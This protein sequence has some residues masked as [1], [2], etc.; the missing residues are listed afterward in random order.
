MIHLELWHLA[1][2]IVA[3]YGI[4]LS[5]TGIAG[6]GIVAVALFSIALP[7][8]TAVGAVL[9]LLVCGDC[10]A[11]FFY[12]RHAVWRHLIRLFPWAALGII[13]GTLAMGHVNDQQVQLM[14]GVLLIALTLLQL[15]QQRQDRRA[16][17]GTG[18]DGEGDIDGSS[19]AIGIL[20]RG[21]LA[22]IA[23]GLLAGFATMVGNAAG[24]LMILYL[25]A[26]RM[27]KMEFVGTG[28]WYFFCLNLFK[29]PFSCHIGLITPT[30]LMID[31]QLAP[32]AV[33]GAL[34]GKAV[35]K[36]TNQKLFERLAMFFTALAGIWLINRSGLLSPHSAHRIVPLTKHPTTLIR[37]NAGLK[38]RLLPPKPRQLPE[39]VPETCL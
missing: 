10:F 26:A 14:I 25:L 8:R 6:V 16:A 11:V 23:L 7:G 13:L 30:T 22:T 1:A 32:F 37:R 12:R 24:P 27:P 35:L 36:H 17:T 29:V 2:A 9:P 19:A 18:A 4:G 28:A 38:D 34:S 39:I 21:G 20:A 15:F 31:L 3:A 5:K 33:L